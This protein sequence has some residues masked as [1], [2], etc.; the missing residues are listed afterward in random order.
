MERAWEV[1]AFVAWHSAF[2]AGLAIVAFLA[3]A[4]LLRGFSFDSASEELSTCL[5]LGLGVV[6]FLIF[7][8]GC[9]GVLTRAAVVGCVGLVLIAARREALDLAGRLSKLVREASAIDWI[10]VGLILVVLAPAAFFALYPPTAFDATEYYLAAAKMFVQEHRVMPVPNLRVEV[11]SLFNTMLFTLGLLF[12]D[13]AAA[14]LTQW[15]AVVGIA[16]A[17]LAMGRRI[18][19]PRAGLL[20]LA[21]VLGNPLLLWLGSNAV[22]DAGTTLYYALALATFWIWF[23]GR[24]ERMLALAAVFSGFAAACKYTGLG[25]V[26]LLGLVALVEGV[27]QRR[28]AT[29]FLFGAF[30]LLAAGPWFLFNYVHSRNPIFPLAPGIFGLGSLG[31]WSI[32]DVKGVMGDLRGR[33]VPLTPKGLITLPWYLAFRPVIFEWGPGLSPVYFFALPLLAIAVFRSRP[34]LILTGFTV[35]FTAAWV[36]NAQIKRH[37]VS[38]LPVFSVACAGA[39]EMSLAWLSRKPLVTKLI[40]APLAL[41]LAYPAVLYAWERKRELEALPVTAED[42]HAS[43]ARTHPSYLAYLFLNETRGQNYHLY[44]LLDTDMAFFADGVY[45][46]DWFGRQRYGDLFRRWNDSR[47]LYSHLRSLGATHFLINKPALKRMIA[48]LSV[49]TDEFFRQ[50]FRLIFH[51]ES[52]M[53]FELTDGAASPLP[54]GRANL[55]R[56]PGFESEQGGLPTDWIP[57]GCRLDRTGLESKAGQAAALC[58]SDAS[59]FSQSVPVHPGSI[60]RLS[61]WA[62]AKGAAEVTRFQVNWGGRAPLPPNIETV[63][64]EPRWELFSTHFI[65]PRGAE[66]ALVFAT[67]H[68]RSA[69]WFDEMTFEE[70]P[71]NESADAQRADRGGALANPS[72]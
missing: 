59:A 63:E 19:G 51:H 41:L 11:Y 14:Q 42:R 1:I 70:I 44:A 67:P 16:V 47:A 23:D 21:L 43:L 12:V 5:G 10:A 65:A 39:I 29:P 18:F 8:L 6:A 55:L 40:A 54:A 71:R 46:G 3:G 60:Y 53:L 25:L 24:Q 35:I 45:T 13:E 2:I 4:R 66:R 50:H 32:E 48:K 62:R 52:G 36:V 37:L 34:A 69:I 72:P 58:E 68:G 33:G 56:N 15:L 27:R 26:G 49:P 57:G 22:I 20:A 9:A 38:V 28:W 30:A 61:F 64:V 31:G 17:T 7:G